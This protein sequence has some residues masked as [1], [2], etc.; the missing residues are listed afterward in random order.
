MVDHTIIV[1]DD[2]GMG[3]FFENVD[4]CYKLLFLST[5]HVGVIH[6]FP[7]ESFVIAETTHFFNNSKRSFADLRDLFVFG[8][9]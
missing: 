3:Q 1:L 7:N 8:K 5:G 4:F 9:D 6:L 2:V